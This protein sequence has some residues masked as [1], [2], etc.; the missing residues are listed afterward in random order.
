MLIDRAPVLLDPRDRPEQPLDAG[1]ET[2]ERTLF[3]AAETLLWPAQAVTSAGW[4]AAQR[5]WEEET[6]PAAIT[7]GTI[8]DRG[9]D[10]LVRGF[11]AR[12]AYA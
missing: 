2:V 3:G 4:S 9:G 1:A 8:I 11:C 5:R 10:F 6:L 12:Y 7:A